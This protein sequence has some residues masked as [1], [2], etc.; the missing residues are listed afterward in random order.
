[1][2]GTHDRPYTQSHPWLAFGAI[3]LSRIAA[4]F[5]VL[6]GEAHSKIEHLSFA[7]LRPEVRDEMLSVYLAKGAHATTAIEGN[8]L[9]EEQVVEIVEGRATTPPAS[10]AY[11][12]QEVANIVAAYNHIK[13]ELLQGAD[14]RLTVDLVKQFNRQVLDGIEE[15]GVTP[16]EIRTG[17][18]VVGPRYRGAPAQDC[19]YLLDRLCDWLNSSDFEPPSPYFTTPYALIK[20]MIAHLYL[21][22]IHPFDN[23]NGRTARLM[24]LQIL[25]ASGVPMPAAHLLSNHYNVTREEYY[26]QLQ[27]ASDSGGDVRGFLRYALQGFVD[28]IRQQVMWVWGQQYADRWQ[29]FIYE[30]FGGRPTSDA[31]RRRFALV[32]ELSR[33][34]EPVARR[35]IPGL[36]A[37]LGSAYAG[38]QRM[39]S[40]DL[41]AL[42]DLGL[43]EQPRHGYWRAARDQILAFRPLRRD[44]AME[45]A[46]AGEQLTLG[47]A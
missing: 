15:P 38:T 18:V 6:L 26:R 30:A 44:A 24:E 9:S 16:G 3:D 42:E 13:D 14:A 17:S 37:E 43:I 47:A 23:G 7:L 35:E 4:E 8:T 20:A 41:N 19:E 31:E 34:W 40:R 39:L 12:H 36:S 10:Q 29:L 11:L 21:A 22:W 27:A 1:M 28:G 46:L 33:R 25:M 32:Q 5:W 2:A 45:R